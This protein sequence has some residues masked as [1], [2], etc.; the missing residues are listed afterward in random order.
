MTFQD[1]AV[2]GDL[3]LI[4]AS[5][6]GRRRRHEPPAPQAEREPSGAMRIRVRGRRHRLDTLLADGVD[7]LSS[8]ELTLRARQLN[9]PSV[10]QALARGLRRAVN[11]AQDERVHMLRAA[12]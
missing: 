8:A 11:D 3:Q 12:V 5:L 1:K 4:E 6:Q 10:R 9:Q 2:E 7:P